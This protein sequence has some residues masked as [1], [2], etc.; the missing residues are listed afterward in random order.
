MWS[1]GSSMWTCQA[2][3]RCHHNSSYNTPTVWSILEV[4]E[5]DRENYETEWICHTRPGN[6][7][8]SQKQLK[9]YVLKKFSLA[10]RFRSDIGNTCSI[11]I[12]TWK[13]STLTSSTFVTLMNPGLVSFAFTHLSICDMP[14]INIKFAAM[15]FGYYKSVAPTCLDGNWVV[16]KKQQL[17]TFSKS[18]TTTYM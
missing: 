2:A 6:N 15:E 8:I 3:N 4:I 11:N 14:L 16:C 13:I 18:H 10:W 1:S 9:I 7:L 5:K 17:Y 12:V